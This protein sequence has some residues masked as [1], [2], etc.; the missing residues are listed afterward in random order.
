MNQKERKNT[1]LTET[2][3]GFLASC[4]VIIS[5]FIILFNF[6]GLE[7]SAYLA[8]LIVDLVY[9]I[10]LFGYILLLSGKSRSEVL[11]QVITLFSIIGATLSILLLWSVFNL[12]I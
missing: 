5:A 6:V 9:I 2:R 12:Q 7:A 10:A 8:V 1:F 11:K 3:R 4:L